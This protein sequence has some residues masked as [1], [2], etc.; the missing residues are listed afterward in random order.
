[1]G[2][3]LPFQSML[4]VAYNLSLTS[5]QGYAKELILQIQSYIS[6]GSLTHFPLAT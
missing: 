2:L 1:M 5:L 6:K 4:A 3:P